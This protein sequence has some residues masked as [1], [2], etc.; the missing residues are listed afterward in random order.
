M[1]TE[2]EQPQ[3]HP[4]PVAE[5]PAPAP[6]EVA[7]PVEA[8]PQPV[9]E[10]PPQAV[11]HPDAV[12]EQL[13]SVMTEQQAPETTIEQNPDTFLEDVTGSEQQ[14]VSGG[15]SQAASGQQQTVAQGSIVKDEVVVAVEK[16][17]EEGLGEYYGEMPDAAKQRFHAK[18]EQVA[19]EIAKMIRDVTFQV[20]R[21]LHLIKDWLHTIPGVN[22]FFLEQ[23]SKIKTDR[24][25]ILDSDRRA[26]SLTPA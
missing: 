16:I 9:P 4:E 20:K 12:A 2:V 19:F 21:V 14:G 22:K 24:L 25:I 1:N 6:V 3:T 5:T 18:G 11:P 13:S 7:P 17:L 15:A 26:A 10:T 8:P 23:E